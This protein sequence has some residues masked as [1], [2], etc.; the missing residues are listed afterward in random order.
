MPSQ[1]WMWYQL[2]LHALSRLEAANYWV[3]VSS[4]ENLQLSLDLPSMACIALAC[5]SPQNRSLL[6]MRRAA[7]ELSFRL[8]WCSCMRHPREA[9][10]TSASSAYA[11][12][13]AAP[14]R[15]PTTTPGSDQVVSAGSPSRKK[16]AGTSRPRDDGGEAAAQLR[17]NS[18]LVAEVLHY[19]LGR[20]AFVHKSRPAKPKSRRR[21][22]M[23]CTP[24]NRGA[25][26]AER[27][28]Q[29]GKWAVEKEPW[30]VNAC[31]ASAARKTLTQ[32]PK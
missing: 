6:R 4:P 23:R 24:H 10:Q 1:T 28:R 9:D 25:A 22:Q 7:Q 3:M 31:T 16:V 5:I 14:V 20:N 17:R 27:P 15:Q 29:A 26:M 30:P 19:A 18:L 2:R 8:G 21:R 13:T 11:P 32:K 12:V